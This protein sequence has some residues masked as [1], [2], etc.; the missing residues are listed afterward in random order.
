MVGGHE[1][2]RAGKNLNSWFILA[3]NS[4]ETNLK[5]L[6]CNSETVLFHPRKTE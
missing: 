6:I 4:G 3:Q 2:L 5:L 1:K